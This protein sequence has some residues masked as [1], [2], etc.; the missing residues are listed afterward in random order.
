MNVMFEWQEQYL[1][2]ERRERA[3]YCFCHSNIKFI[4]SS[5][6]LYSFY[7]VDILMTAFLTIFGRFPTTF[8]RFPKILEN[9]SKDHV[10]VAKQFPA[11]SIHVDAR[12]FLTIAEDF[13][14]RPED[15]SIIHRR[16]KEQFMRNFKS[17]KSSISSLVRIWK[18]CHLSPRCSFVL[19]LLVVYF[20]VKY[21]CL[22]VTPNT[23]RITFDSLDITGSL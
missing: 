22:K 15:V 21:L 9:L 1:T 8:R 13:R 14:G 12:R 6:M 17:V 4:S 19:I 5:Y 11:I 18:I 10:N 23:Y 7:Y 3:R 20:P 16:I 2:S